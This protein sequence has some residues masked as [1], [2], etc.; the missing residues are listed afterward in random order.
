MIVNIQSLEQQSS[1]KKTALSLIENNED[2]NF[3]FISKNKFCAVPVHEDSFNE[4]L[5]VDFFS[6]C[7]ISVYAVGTENNHCFDISNVTIEEFPSLQND[8]NYFLALSF[9]IFPKDLSFIIFYPYGDYWIIAGQKQ[10]V[11]YVA[12]N[13]I[14]N[15]RIKFLQ[16]YDYNTD[17]SQNVYDKYRGYNG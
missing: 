9:I 11:E 14:G 8:E 16:D 5:V 15:A 7:D 4:K 13:T 1:L 3:D 12:D 10:F 2:I 6:S 17:V